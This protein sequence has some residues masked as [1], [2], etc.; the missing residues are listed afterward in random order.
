M[1]PLRAVSCSAPLV[2]Q[3]LVSHLTG[4]RAST[5]SHRKSGYSSDAV[6]RCAQRIERLTQ[7]EPQWADDAHGH[8]GYTG[9]GT[10]SVPGGIFAH[11]GQKRV[12]DFLLLS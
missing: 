4:S 11:F 1:Q 12:R 6:A 7:P 3:A 2:E 8:H 10:F 9:R 5:F